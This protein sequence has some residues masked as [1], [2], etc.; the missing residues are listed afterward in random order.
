MI[1]AKLG[2]SRGRWGPG[3]GD[4]GR[5]VTAT[6][7]CQLPEFQLLMTNLVRFAALTTP[8]VAESGVSIFPF[9]FPVQRH[10]ALARRGTRLTLTLL[11]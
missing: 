11:G 4:S 7:Y 8:Y 1:A 2:E 9:E 3:A 6:R 10:R 5:S